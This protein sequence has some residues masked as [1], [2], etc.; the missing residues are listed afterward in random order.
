ML[1]PEQQAADEA[2]PVKTLR[3]FAQQSVELA[4]IVARNF[5]ADPKL[6]R[7]L[8]TSPDQDVRCGVAV[9]PNVPV[10]VLFK[11]GEEFPKQLLENPALSLLLLENPNLFD[12]LPHPTVNSILK[13]ERIPTFFLNW[14]INHRRINFS[15]WLAKQP[16]TPQR[17][18]VE[19]A[20]RSIAEQS[21]PWCE[22]LE[23]VIQDPNTPDDVLELIA[24][25]DDR[26]RNPMMDRVDTALVARPKLPKPVIEILAVRGAVSTK[27]EIA[28]RPISADL[29][30]TLAKDKS[31][32]WL[33]CTV[34]LNPSTP[35][36]LLEE[37]IVGDRS[38][39]YYVKHSVALSPNLSDRLVF[40]LLEKY[41]FDTLSRLE[42]NPHLPVTALEKLAK[43]STKFHQ[44]L[45]AKH[46]NTPMPILMD[47][48]QNDPSMH[49]LLA[50]NPA[51]PEE[52]IRQFLKSPSAS[53]R[54]GVAENPNLPE[55][56]LVQLSTDPHVN[57][58]HAAQ[59]ALEA[60]KDA[61]S[62]KAWEEVYF[63]PSVWP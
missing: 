41:D 44:L 63:S 18:L 39:P 54:Q 42:T 7:K 20:T 2:T 25:R 31:E 15:I 35:E 3:E 36:D 16:D 24:T 10:D 27:I 38:N 57:V 51:M 17:T 4:R 50:R 49:T 14:A 11:L 5:C 58:R 23:S 28:R 37:L 60:L 43:S 40:L 33:L 52:I 1:T 61:N 13:E 48:F 8:A 45:A 59:K 9:N 55:P 19:Q 62:R 30:R 34:A 6:L 46:P 22:F 12:T 47:W 32:V 53:I 21:E 26:L 56:F 29:L